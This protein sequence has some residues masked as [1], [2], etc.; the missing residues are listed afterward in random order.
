MPANAAGLISYGEAVTGAGE[1]TGRVG[2]VWAEEWKRTDRSFAHLTDR[3]LDSTAL[4]N[5]SHA[6][7]IG[8]GAGE[9]SIALASRDFGAAIT[10]LDIS[11]ALLSIARERG[12][13]L[14]NIGFHHADAATWHP[15]KP[16][17]APDLLISRHGVMF[18][19]DPIAAFAHLRS[20]V[21]DQA[22]LRFSCF[23][24]RD[25]N[26]WAGLLQG[27]LPV[28]PTTPDPHA[29]GP[30]A[31]GNEDRV[32]MILRDAGWKDIAFEPLDYA[33]IAG[34]GEDALEEAVAY[35]LRI[36]PAASAITALEGAARERA[37]ANLRAMLADHRKQDRIAL[38]AAAWI[39]TARAG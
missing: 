36:G 12:A 18:F 28:Q 10:G 4:E 5:F 37:I 24:A 19:G 15:D 30:F 33:M 2:G 39:V 13:G 32:S 38:P 9:I 20:V 6:L 26:G 35:F 3:L 27:V 16:E 14:P 17:A 11:P 8:C 31:F 23:R 22:S 34:N 25:A 7:D 29:P 21:S 1:W